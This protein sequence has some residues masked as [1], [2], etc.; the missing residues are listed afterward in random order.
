MT[1]NDKKRFT[2]RMPT[3]L[4]N[5][6]QELANSIGVTRNTAIVQILRKGI[7]KAKKKEEVL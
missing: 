5:E 4:Y 2:L 3:N 6:I 1:N 7:K